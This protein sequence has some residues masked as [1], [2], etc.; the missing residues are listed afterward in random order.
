MFF[1]GQLSEGAYALRK[2]DY[3][4]YFLA[5]STREVHMPPNV[6][7]GQLSEGAY[8]LRENWF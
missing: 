4:L 1:W 6:F 2:N 5:V 3:F 7:W 8:A